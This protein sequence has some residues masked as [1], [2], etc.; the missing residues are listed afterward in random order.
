MLLNKMKK[1]NK[2]IYQKGELVEEIGK[3]NI[4][5][6]LTLGAGD[7]DTFVEPIKNKLLNR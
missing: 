3:R 6:L 4:E 2:S 7:I 5:V 1:T